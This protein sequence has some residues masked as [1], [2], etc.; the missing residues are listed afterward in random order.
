M[1]PRAIIKHPKT[2]L[3]PKGKPGQRQPRFTE[4]SERALFARFPARG[5]IAIH[6]LR[7]RFGR[8]PLTPLPPPLPPT[9]IVAALAIHRRRI[10]GR[11]Y[12]YINRCTIPDHH[13][14]LYAIVRDRKLYY[15]MHTVEGEGGREALLVS[16]RL[17]RHLPTAP[18]CFSPLL[19]LH[20][21]PFL[22]RC[23]GGEGGGGES[24]Q[25]G[26]LEFSGHMGD[27]KG[28]GA[29]KERERESERRKEEKEGRGKKVLAM[30]RT[31]ATSKLLVL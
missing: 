23:G 1:N 26:A 17:S 4:T 14:N 15:R 27:E 7:F 19:L 31:R 30:R 16:T 12:G 6:T 20:T 2:P 13:K 24:V 29:K 22:P 11:V 3:L 28:G 5:M 8:P 18:F 9:V 21:F 25:A 10:R